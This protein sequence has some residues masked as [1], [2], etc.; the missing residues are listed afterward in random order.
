M[1]RN[2]RVN[3]LCNDTSWVCYIWERPGPITRPGPSRS[4]AVVYAPGSI[5]RWS[6]AMDYCMAQTRLHP[7]ARYIPLT[8]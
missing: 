7:E 2:M 8:K 4:V 6:D 3:L 1:A 5:Q